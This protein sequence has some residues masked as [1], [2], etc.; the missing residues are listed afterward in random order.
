MKSK[1]KNQFEIS[2][3]HSENISPSSPRFTAFTNLNHLMRLKEHPPERLL[4]SSGI[5]TS[6]LFSS[7]QPIKAT[8][9]INFPMTHSS[10]VCEKK[11]KKFPSPP[12]LIFIVRGEMIYC[13]EVKSFCMWNENFHRLL[14]PS[15][16][17]KRHFKE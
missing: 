13:I 9:N 6:T 2:R 4:G 11:K 7:F 17:P 3:K 1:L 8:Q 5:F 16:R 10:L 14:L 15:K 12:N